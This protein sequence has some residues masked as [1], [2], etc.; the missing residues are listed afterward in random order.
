MAVVW[1]GGSK[2]Q[3]EFILHHVASGS[4]I[5]PC[6]EATGGASE[7]DIHFLK[8][9]TTRR[10]NGSYRD[11]AAPTSQDTSRDCWQWKWHAACSKTLLLSSSLL[12]QL[13]KPFPLQTFCTL[14]S[15]LLP[16]IHPSSVMNEMQCRFP[17]PGV[18]CIRCPF[19]CKIKTFGWT[20][21][22]FT[23][24]LMLWYLI[25]MLSSSQ[26][27]EIKLVHTI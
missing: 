9:V 27:L 8:N 22:L 15:Q 13:G 5:V 11:T 3:K 4:Y 23:T 2:S 18:E 20:F 16:M 17:N 6:M 1:S 10:S 25:E 19:Y 21:G 14:Q 26:L 12:T 24:N 7:A